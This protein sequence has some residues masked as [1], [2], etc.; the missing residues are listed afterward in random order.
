[1][2]GDGGIHGQGSHV[3]VD[4]LEEVDIPAVAGGNEVVEVH[5]EEEDNR[6]QAVAGGQVEEGSMDRQAAEHTP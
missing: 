1:M 4:S 2:V 6:T 5:G 3:A